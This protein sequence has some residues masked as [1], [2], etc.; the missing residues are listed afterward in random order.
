[1]GVELLKR[2]KNY[3]SAVQSS[4]CNPD[5]GFSGASVDGYQHLLLPSAPKM[6]AAIS[7]TFGTQPPDCVVSHLRYP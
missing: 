6:E 5:R 2:Q 3:M 1:M 4:F 7:I